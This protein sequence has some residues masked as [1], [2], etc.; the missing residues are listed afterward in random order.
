MTEKAG[1]TTIRPLGPRPEPGQVGAN[2][3]QELSPVNHIEGIGKVDFEQDFASFTRVAE[4]PLTHS[5]RHSLR[6]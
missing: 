2:L 3:A 5:M 1:V 6:A 4:E